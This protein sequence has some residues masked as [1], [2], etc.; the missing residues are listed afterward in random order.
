MAKTKITLLNSMAGKDF[1]QY[2]SKK[3]DVT[4]EDG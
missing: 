3:I 1:E 4:L 2:K